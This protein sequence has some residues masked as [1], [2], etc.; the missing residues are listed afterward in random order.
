MAE[1]P[2]AVL[3]SRSKE[4]GH[5][6][7]CTLSIAPP[8]QSISRW[9]AHVLHGWR[10]RHVLNNECW[11]GVQSCRWRKYHTD[12]AVA[13]NSTTGADASTRP[14]LATT[15]TAA[16][17]WRGVL[18]NCWCWC[19][20]GHCGDSLKAFDSDC[21]RWHD[22]LNAVGQERV[23]HGWRG[24]DVLPTVGADA[25]HGTRQ[26]P[27]TPRS[28]PKALR[29]PVKWRNNCS[30]KRFRKRTCQGC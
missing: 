24:H 1:P 6:L 20:D 12:D 5:D 19:S 29:S 9:A 27:Q 4:D 3:R 7:S 17:T 13:M 10:W 8:L 14:V 22:V 26:H 25:L 15:S 30:P 16:A 21:W 2:P 11:R 28:R 18:R 23:G